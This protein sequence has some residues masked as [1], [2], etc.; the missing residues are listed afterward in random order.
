MRGL[1][2]TFHK[3]AIH[4]IPYPSGNKCPACVNE[5][6]RNEV[7][8]DLRFLQLTKLI[9]SWSKDPSTRVGAVIVDNLHRVVSLGYNGLPRTMKDDPRILDNRELKYKC[10]IHAEENAILFSNRPLQDCS[11]YTYPVPP[12]ARCASKIVQSGIT[13]VV[14]PYVDETSEFWERWKEHLE[15]A[16]RVFGHAVEMRFYEIP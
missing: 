15:L 16:R 3:C 7:K 10:I 12:C 1:G 6:I 14:A 11:I 2:E 4:G 9:S 8:W 5:E 13:R